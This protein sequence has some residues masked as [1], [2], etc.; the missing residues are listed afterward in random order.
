[1]ILSEEAAITR[2]NL[3]QIVRE[4]PEKILAELTQLYAEQKI[5]V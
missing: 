2:D 4:N 1:M 3:K 5:K